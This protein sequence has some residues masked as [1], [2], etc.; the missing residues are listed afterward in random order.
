MRRITVEVE[1]VDP[2]ALVLAPLG[3]GSPHGQVMDMTV[4]GGE[5]AGLQHEPDL[6][7]AAALVRASGGAL[8]FAHNVDPAPAAYPE[9]A[10][11]PRENRWTAPAAALADA[12]RDIAAAAGGGRAGIEA[13][14]AEA[15]AKFTYTHPEARFTD[16]RED[17]PH[18]SCGLTEGSC[19]DI[20]TY[21]V[22][23]LRAAGYEAAYVYG[24]FFPAERGGVTRDM[25]C[26]VVTRHEGEAL[27]WDI[28]HHMK[29]ALGPTR[30]APNPKPGERVAFGHSMGHRYRIDG[31]DVALRYLPEPMLLNGEDPGAAIRVT[32]RL[33]IRLEDPAAAPAPARTLARGAA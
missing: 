1:A 5:I 12:S 2:G 30:P 19:T 4:A 24:Y 14:V 18:L 17:V 33:A 21:L 13:L 27:E 28:A 25:H 22:A 9:A 20:N 8:T 3:L 32:E 23:S 6:G 11:R 16:G 29:G 15:E 10:F 26:W 7:L 31:R